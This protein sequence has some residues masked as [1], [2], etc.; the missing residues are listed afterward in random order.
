M[1]SSQISNNQWNS[2]SGTIDPW[3]ITSQDIHVKNR[4][5]VISRQDLVKNIAQWSNVWTTSSDVNT[6]KFIDSL[7]TVKAKPQKPKSDE[8]LFYHVSPG[9]NWDMSS[10]Q[11]TKGKSYNITSHIEEELVQ[12]SRYKTELCR[13]WSETGACRYGSKC[14]FAHGKGE[15]RPVLRHPKYKTELCRSW[16]E[17]GRCPYGNRCRFVHNERK[18][19]Y[20]QDDAQKDKEINE[21]LKSFPDVMSELSISGS[22]SHTDEST[23]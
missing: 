22:S 23:S 13:S 20:D 5:K 9:Q 8:Y 15:L 10:Q 6:T 4:P 11:E 1:S 18:S 7:S 3:S 17:T 2:T 12:Q 16:T 14:Q 21:L 19:S